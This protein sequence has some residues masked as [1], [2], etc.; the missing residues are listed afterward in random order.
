MIL[1][2]CCQAGVCLCA[3]VEKQFRLSLHNIH[4]L[5]PDNSIILFYAI[6]VFKKVIL[7]AFRERWLGATTKNLVC[8]SMNLLSYPFSGGTNRRHRSNLLSLKIVIFESG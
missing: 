2:V 4:F 3:F 1:L 5:H 6:P 7:T 8:V